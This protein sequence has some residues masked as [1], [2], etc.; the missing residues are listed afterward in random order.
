[1]NATYNVKNGMGTGLYMNWYKIIAEYP[2]IDTMVNAWLEDV[3][4]EA[5]IFPVCLSDALQ[6][7]QMPSHFPRVG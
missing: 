1:M 2:P 4:Y 5:D 7:G 3:T 6:G